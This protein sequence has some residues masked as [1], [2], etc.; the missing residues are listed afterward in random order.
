MHKWL[1]FRNVNLLS[2]RKD[3]RER[4]FE[5]RRRIELYFRH[6]VNDVAANATEIL[7]ED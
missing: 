2:Q 5:R 7:P 6:M 4:A 3:V 1:A